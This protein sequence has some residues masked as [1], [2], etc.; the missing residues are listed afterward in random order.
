MPEDTIPDR[1]FE[2]ALQRLEAIVEQLE[3]QPPN[4][5]EALD[6]YEEGV[7]LARQCLER[8]D[9]AEMRVEELSL[10]DAE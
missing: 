7:S 3:D 2:E 6:A 1:S 9:A 8:L 10:E 4:L 5:E